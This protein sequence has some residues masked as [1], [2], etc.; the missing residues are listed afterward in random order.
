MKLISRNLSAYLMRYINT[1]IVIYL[2]EKSVPSQ[3]YFWTR[4][5]NLFEFLLVCLVANDKT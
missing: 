5:R 4:K 2:Q 1:F 3:K